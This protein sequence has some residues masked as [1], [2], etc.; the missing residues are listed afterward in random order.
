M[1]AF[2]DYCFCFQVTGFFYQK[3]EFL[4]KMFIKQLP[5]FHKKTYNWKTKA[6]IFKS[7]CNFLDIIML[8]LLGKFEFDGWFHF[9]QKQGIII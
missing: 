9:F 2:E 8:M 4:F 1:L 3:S 6:V 7:Y 5:L